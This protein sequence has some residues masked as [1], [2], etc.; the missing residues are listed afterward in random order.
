[1]W[2]GL[3]DRWCARER[4]QLSMEGGE[5]EVKGREGQALRQEGGACRPQRKEPVWVKGG[6]DLT[7]RFSITALKLWTPRKMMK[8]VSSITHTMKVKPSPCKPS[9]VNAHP[10]PCF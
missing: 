1:M 7:L 10:F 8:S 4:V 6:G 9:V 5:G 3:I 2:G